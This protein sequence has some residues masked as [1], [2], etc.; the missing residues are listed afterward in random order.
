[1]E[2][3]KKVTIAYYAIGSAVKFNKKKLL[4][5]DGTNEYYVLLKLLL[6][7]ENVGK[8]IL[9][10]RSDWARI[11]LKDRLVIDPQHKVIDPF[12]TIPS[13]IMRKS[14]KAVGS[15]P[16]TDPE[17][18]VAYYSALYEAIK[19]IHIDFGLGFTSQG[20]GT[21]ALPG[22]TQTLRPPFRPAGA[23]D[24]TMLY[25]SD[26]LYYL[27]KTNLKWFLLATDPRYVKPSMRQRDISNLPQIILGQQ[28]FTAKWFSLKEFDRNASLAN[29]GYVIRDVKSI[30]SG[31]EKINL[32]DECVLDTSEI[33]K[34][35]KFTTVSM[36]LSE[37]KSEKDLRFDIL[38]EYILKYDKDCSARIFGKWSPFFKKDRPQFKGYIATE[39]LDRI[40][41]ETRYTLVLPTAAGWVTSKYAEMLLL[42]VLPFFHPGYDT[43]GHV[44]PMDH[45]IRVKS[46][47]DFYA[48]MEY[49]D[50][51]PQDRI[52]I[53]A[54]LQ[55]T[56]CSDA[57]SGRFMIE[58]LNKHL[59]EAGLN[60][61]KL[62]ESDNSFFEKRT[63]TI[64]QKDEG[65]AEFFS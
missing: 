20:W 25:A 3:K 40:F 52:A 16:K 63:K 32:I 15:M 34:P 11:S 42:G 46:P 26:I 60:N 5:S 41:S 38:N 36:Q 54:N 57:Y 14:D 58:L 8:V 50:K 1:M 23:L 30:Y 22:F 48:K 21:C 61:I 24:M 29:D 56:L 47:E 45:F 33:E 19:D 7:N 39:D 49:L 13:L 10:S 35:V 51:N 59:A 18:K 28:E 55:K 27:S 62:S 44:V 6:K 12:S 31:I 4:R 43:Q 2:E 65:L 37:P 53:V 17:E 9:L 64:Q